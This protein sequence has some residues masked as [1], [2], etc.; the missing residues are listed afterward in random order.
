M[1]ASGSF[2]GLLLQDQP[3]LGS[4]AWGARARHVVRVVQ[5]A[6]S[7]PPHSQMR[8]VEWMSLEAAHRLTVEH[9][10]PPPSLRRRISSRDPG[11]PPTAQVSI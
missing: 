10:P 9:G 6:H 7:L 8:V 1:F 2:R 11:S 4:R 5:V 3:V